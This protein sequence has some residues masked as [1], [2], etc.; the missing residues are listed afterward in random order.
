MLEH[1]YMKNRV[2]R[3]VFVYISED[4]VQPLT[5]SVMAAED[6]SDILSRSFGWY[7]LIM[8]PHKR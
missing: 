6:R 5:R 1:L 7:E 2:V 4:L 8:K 3:G